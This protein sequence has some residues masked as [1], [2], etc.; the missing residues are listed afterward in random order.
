MFAEHYIFQLLEEIIQPIRVHVMKYSLFV[1][2]HKE[3]MGLGLR[4]TDR[5]W[6]T[7]IIETDQCIVH[8]SRCSTLWP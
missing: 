3:Q 6:K 1:R 8:D 2:I 7:E 5:L 4:V